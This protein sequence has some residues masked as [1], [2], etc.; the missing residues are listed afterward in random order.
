MRLERESPDPSAKVSLAVTIPLPCSRECVRATPAAV[1]PS[2]TPYAPTSL[3][4]VSAMKLSLS[5]FISRRIAG[6]GGDTDAPSER[7]PAGVTPVVRAPRCATPL[8]ASDAFSRCA[9]ASG[10][11]ET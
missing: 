10:G 9:A 3:A 2:P 4:S 7:A 5:W 11:L 1:V 8:A 6:S